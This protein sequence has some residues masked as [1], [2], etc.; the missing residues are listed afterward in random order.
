M[1]VST[2]LASR[3]IDLVLHLDGQDGNVLVIAR[4][5]LDEIKTLAKEIREFDEKMKQP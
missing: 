3:A 2:D 1:I 5:S 4:E